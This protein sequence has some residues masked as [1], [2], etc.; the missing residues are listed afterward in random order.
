[1]SAIE[2]PVYLTTAELAER[3]RKSPAT[4][5][6]WRFRGTGP[7]YLKPSGKRG[8]ALYPLE[9]V[10]AWEDRHLKGRGQ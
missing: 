4:L 1:M 7:A 10:V 9:S 6:N 3:W 2:A 5:R 8:E